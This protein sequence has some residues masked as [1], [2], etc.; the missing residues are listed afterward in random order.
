F[1]GCADGIID[2]IF[3]EDGTVTGMAFS[4]SQNLM[5][6]SVYSF[7]TDRT[8]AFWGGNNNIHIDA[9]QVNYPKVNAVMC[10]SAANNAGI[11]IG[12]MT[13]QQNEQMCGYAGTFR[14]ASIGT[15]LTIDSLE[16]FNLKG[17]Q[18]RCTSTGNSLTIN[19]IKADGNRLKS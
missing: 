11:S 18:I 1:D 17:D 3:I 14:F 19:N 5:I 2:E 8:I 12:H 10:E 4:N 9:L 7:L 16:Q 13:V 15:D 6:G